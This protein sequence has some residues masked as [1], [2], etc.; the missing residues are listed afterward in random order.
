MGCEKN[1]ISFEKNNIER[2]ILHSK[3]KFKIADSL[4]C[5]EADLYVKAKGSC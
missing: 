5:M 1:I 3:L 2:H 4:L